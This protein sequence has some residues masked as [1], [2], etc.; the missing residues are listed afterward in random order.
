M[1]STNKVTLQINLSPADYLHAVH[2]L[3]HQLKALSTQVN[4]IILTVDT[5]PGKGRFADDWHQNI[6][7]LNLYLSEN[8]RLLYNVKIIP[9]DYSITVKQKVAEYFFGTSSIPD[10]DFRGGPFYAY[11]FGLHMAGNDH[12]FHL[13]SDIFLGGGSHTWV[14]EAIE[15]FE[16][17]K[18]CLI[19]SPLPGPPHP[20]GKLIRQ[21][22]I[23]KIAAHTYQLAGM[24]TRV[25]MIDRSRFKTNKLQL[26]KPGFRNQVKAIVEGNSNADLPEHLLSVYLKANHLKRVDFLGDNPGLWSLH[27]PYRTKQFF[28]ELP[29]LIARIENNDMPKSQLGFYDVVDELCDWEPA[30]KLLEHNRWWTRL[31]K[32]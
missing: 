1:Q 7:Q 22:V 12:I 16:K 27:P 21:Q 28:D 11:F 19:L 23:S 4:E 20:Q 25:F 8:I 31:L 9:V 29:A 3:P 10:K 24:S 32:N 14:K 17:D 13:D 2:I 5:L 15:F 18:Q 30:I 26:T 6:D